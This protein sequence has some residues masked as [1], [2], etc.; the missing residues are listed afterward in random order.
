M[1]IQFIRIDDRL[2]HGQVVTAWIK[3]YQAKNVLIVDDGVAKDEFL[4]SVLKMAAPSGIKLFIRG[5]EDLE[6]TVEQFEASE[7]NTVVLLKTP[8]TA[9]KLFDAGVKIRELNV[10]G[11]GANRYRKG[12]YKN[13]SASEEELQVLNGLEEEGVKVYFRTVPADRE[14]L[15]NSIVKK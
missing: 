3:N 12:L 8:Q 4:Q 10:G 11:M 15:L 9:K 13:I 7:K 14:V 5:T 1:S 2:I 6:K